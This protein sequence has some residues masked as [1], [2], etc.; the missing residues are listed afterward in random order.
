MLP[1]GAPV[2]TRFRTCTNRQ[3]HMRVNVRRNKRCT[4]MQLFSQ[5]FFQQMGLER[6]KRMH[7][8]RIAI[9]RT[10]SHTQ[11][12]T[13]VCARTDTAIIVGW[14]HKQEGHGS[15]RFVPLVFLKQHSS[16]CCPS[17]ATAGSHGREGALD[18]LFYL[19][20]ALS[21]A[22]ELSLLSAA[23]LLLRIHV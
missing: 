6:N 16:V 4:E 3:T 5:L 7:A 8:R 22:R 23:L 17:A 15:D 2:A 20:S 13:H 18:A 10:R 12:C 14:E 11:T 21:V 19:S 9:T 1:A